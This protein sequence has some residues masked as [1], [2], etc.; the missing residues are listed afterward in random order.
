MK[1]LTITKEELEIKCGKLENGKVCFGELVETG[2]PEEKQPTKETQEQNTAVINGET[3][4]LTKV[5]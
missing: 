2:L 3:Y 5:L 1:N 4:I